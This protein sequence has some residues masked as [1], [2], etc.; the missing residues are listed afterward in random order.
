MH[1][2]AAVQLTPVSSPEPGIGTG[3]GLGAGTTTHRTP[4]H[5]SVS[6]P[7]KP[8][9]TAMQAAAELQETPVRKDAPP[10]VLGVGDRAQVVPFHRSASVT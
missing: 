2:A 6:G 8:D 1:S 4:F 5:R 3:R 10:R 9:P 7:P